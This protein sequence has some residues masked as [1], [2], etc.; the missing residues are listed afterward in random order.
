MSLPR[1][2]TVRWALLVLAGL[3]FLA[4]M[5]FN[6]PEP[7]ADGAGGARRYEPAQEPCQ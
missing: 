4:G 6:A 3:S 1:R 2:D 5:M 7:G